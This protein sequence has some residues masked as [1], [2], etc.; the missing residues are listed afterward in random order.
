MPWGVAAA[1]IGAGGS[2]LSGVMGKSAAS[3]A[4]AA[5]EQAAQQATAQQQAAYGQA[6]GNLAPYMSAGT[7]ALTNLTNLLGIGAGGAGPSSP[8]LAMLGLAPGG[9]AGQ[10]D[11]TKFYGSPGYQYQ[12]Q[13]GLNAVTNS[14]ARTGLGGNA[15]RELQQ[16]GQGLANQTWNQYLGNA[17]TAWQQLLSNLSS[18]AGSGQ[19]AAT[20][21]SDIGIKVGGQIGANTIGAGNAQASGIVG[22][23]NALSGGISGAIQNILPYLVD[24]NGGG[25]S[26]SGGIFSDQSVGNYSIPGTSTFGPYGSLFGS[27][28]AGTSGGFNNGADL[29]GTDGSV[30]VPPIPPS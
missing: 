4:A 14:N 20:N 13:Q 15:L 9:T 29:I 11:P 16:T 3:S 27:P 17:S 19:N 24:G 25:G 6:Q 18:L 7:N 12:L 26:G 22:G 2:L 5:Q 1:A 30:I 8:I 23:A 10:I 21:L 28:A